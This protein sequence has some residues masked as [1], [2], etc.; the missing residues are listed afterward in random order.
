MLYTDCVIS[1][2]RVIYETQKVDAVGV[3]TVSKLWDRIYGNDP[4]RAIHRPL[5]QYLEQQNRERT[6]REGFMAMDRADP[7]RVA[8]V[9]PV[10]A[11]TGIPGINGTHKVKALVQG[12]P[13]PTNFDGARA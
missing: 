2:E 8:P 13:I 7:Y 12:E 3:I 4:R 11:L 6:I 5:G 10:K 1:M 9:E